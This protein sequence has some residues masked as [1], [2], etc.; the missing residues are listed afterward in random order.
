MRIV[1]TQVLRVRDVML[2]VS[3]SQAILIYIAGEY[4]FGVALSGV[5][6]FQ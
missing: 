2:V 5:G 6:D 1:G 4:E 3:Q